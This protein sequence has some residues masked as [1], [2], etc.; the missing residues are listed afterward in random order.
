MKKQDELTN[1]HSCMSRARD[2]EWTFVLLGRDAAA[3]ATIR[4]WTNE[5]IRLGKN[6]PDDPQIT[7]ALS[8]A[9]QMEDGDGYGVAKRRAVEIVRN[10]F[11][12][13]GFGSRDFNE[14]MVIAQLEQ[15]IATL[16]AERVK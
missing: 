12:A 3:P 16:I 14:A 6:K 7:E 5:R 10:A 4:F 1:P 11:M 13:A 9:A 8:C 15:S 2:D